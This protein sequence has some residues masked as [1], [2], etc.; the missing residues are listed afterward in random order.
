MIEA[1]VLGFWAVWLADRRI[2]AVSEG[3]AFIILVNIMRAFQALELPALGS[4][5]A[6]E[7]AVLWLAVALVFYAVNRYSE[8]FAR[9]LASASAGCLFYYFVSAGIE[10]LLYG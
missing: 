9:T 1:F 2:S 7:M 4:L 3:L 8:T 5:W 6:A 10:S